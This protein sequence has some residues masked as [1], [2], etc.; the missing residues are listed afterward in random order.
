MTTYRAPCMW[1]RRTDKAKRPDLCG[2]W[3]DPDRPDIPNL[4]SHNYWTKIHW[5][6]PPWVDDKLLRDMQDMYRYAR[7]PFDHVDHIVPLKHPLVCGL[8]V[9]WNLR[10]TTR[11]ANL[12]KSNNWWP[13]C[14]DHLCPEKNLPA[15]MFGYEPPH[16]TSLAL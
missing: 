16:Q 7:A 9:P 3:L 8:N 2:T 5:A 12:T 4:V 1:T 14:P 13:D 15:D 11:R 6:T 10:V